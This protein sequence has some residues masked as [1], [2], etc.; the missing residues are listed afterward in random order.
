MTLR[1]PSIFESINARTLTPKQVAQTF[2]PSSH[3]SDLCLR[4]HSI[5]LG[6]RGSGKTT[7]LKMLQPAALETWRHD[8]ADDIVGALDF[9]AIFVSTDITWSEQLKVITESSLEP[10]VAQTLTLACFT[11]QALK[12]LITAFQ[13][14]LGSKNCAAVR[15]V[16]RISLA[17]GTEASIV[18]EIARLW[19]IDSIAPSFF[20]LTKALTRR[21]MQIRELT[22][23]ELVLGSLGRPE[24]I[25]S[26]KMLHLALLQSAGAAIEVFEGAAELDPGKWAYCFDELELAP[27][28]IQRELIRA[29]RSTDE[30][31]LFK[32]SLNPYTTN[33]Y[34]LQ[35]AL[36]PAP[37]QDF[38]QI[39]LWYAQKRFAH[40][41]CEGL[42][43][44]IAKDK[45]VPE[46]T[47]KD[48]L[49]NSYFESSVED[50]EM[51]R[52]AY[53]PGS[54][55]ARRFK[56]LAGKDETFRKYLK[57]RHIDLQGLHLMNEEIRAAEVRKISPIVALREFYL[58]D[59]ETRDKAP[60]S[61]R[62]RKTADLYTGAGSIFSLTEGNPRIFIG[63]ISSL[64]VEA[65]K[66]TKPQVPPHIQA[67][68]VL[69]IAEKFLAVLRSIPV[70]P[71]NG[72]RSVGVMKLLR[73]VARYF[74]D[75]AV[76]ADFQS[77]PVGSFKV[78]QRVPEW[79][80][81]VLGQALNAGAII[82]V[83]DDEGKVILASP[84]GKT[85]RLSYL[86][87]PVYGFPIRMGREKSLSSILQ[88]LPEPSSVVSSL[89]LDFPGES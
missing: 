3:F 12:S 9:T 5:V 17:A 48:V 36:N 80:L 24:R 44:E 52:S 1:T 54:R 6:P 51:D 34:L 10:A 37:G 50:E 62:S 4:R 42:W 29:I 45:G 57:K 20:S 53:A 22:S 78:D 76:R 58:R 25:A 70:N 72:E 41:F 2:V 31:F 33:N 86:L 59:E 40:A 39:S 21:L 89:K 67:E 61:E 75:D 69:T 19:Y 32:L 85:F 38:D 30:R 23:Q 68:L 28:F 84:R 82:Y 43:K 77:E 87:A 63:L 7:L 27:D 73:S 55:W 15:S 56:S 35:G 81:E 8:T 64:I 49:G 13:Q 60:Q 16:R 47:A 65:K 88:L 71:I 11:T 46:W 79:V 74:H 66:R 14:R 18:D 83:P 26:Y